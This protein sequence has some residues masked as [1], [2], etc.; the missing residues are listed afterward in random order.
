MFSRIRIVLCLEIVFMHQRGYV[1][2]YFFF[3][4]VFSKAKNIDNT[5]FYSMEINGEN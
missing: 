5:L 1:P 4:V 2:R 3:V